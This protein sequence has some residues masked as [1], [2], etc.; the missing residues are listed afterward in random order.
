MDVCVWDGMGWDGEWV[1]LTDRPTNNA[2]M[3]YQGTY[4]YTNEWITLPPPSLPQ[5]LLVFPRPFKSGWED[6]HSSHTQTHTHTHTHT[7]RGRH[8]AR[9]VGMQTH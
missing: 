5:L 7:H 9:R 6:A 4:I 1:R 8:T 2:M 3:T